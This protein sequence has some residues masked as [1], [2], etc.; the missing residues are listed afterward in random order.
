MLGIA[1]GAP[2][3]SAEAIDPPTM[4]GRMDGEPK[5]SADGIAPTP[6]ILTAVVIVG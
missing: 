2:K 6:M 4:L 1:E 5:A 3:A